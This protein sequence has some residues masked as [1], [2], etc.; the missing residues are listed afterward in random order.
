M[1]KTANVIQSRCQSP[2]RSNKYSWAL[3]HILDLQ[4]LSVR[5]DLNCSRI[6]QRYILSFLFLV[7][8]AVNISTGAPQPSS[9]PERAEKLTFQRIYYNLVLF[10]RV[11][12]LQPVFFGSFLN[13]GQNTKKQK[14]S[15]ICNKIK[16][17][18]LNQTSFFSQIKVRNKAKI[19]RQA[20]KGHKQ[21]KMRWIM[22]SCHFY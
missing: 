22:T 4:G 20:P 2:F 14:K 21:E 3:I 13:V 7:V 16:K 9:D 19:C 10:K 8:G 15:S 18:I 11:R 12:I 6:N 1:D 5:T 17:M